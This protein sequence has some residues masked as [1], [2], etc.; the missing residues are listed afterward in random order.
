MFMGSSGRCWTS[1]SSKFFQGPTLIVTTVACSS[2][3]LKYSQWT[4]NTVQAH[5][6]EE[7]NSSSDVQKFKIITPFIMS[8]G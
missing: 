3:K 5:A 6:L 4:T 1:Y 2:A 7:G 8:F